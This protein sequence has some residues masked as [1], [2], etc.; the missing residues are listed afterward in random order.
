VSLTAPRP[1]AAAAGFHWAYVCRACTC[2]VR[3]DALRDQL[4][5]ALK[6]EREIERARVKSRP[7]NLARLTRILAYIV[8]DERGNWPV[9]TSCLQ[10][11]LQYSSNFA[12]N[13]HRFSIALHDAPLEEMSVESVR[14]LRQV[15][16]VFLPAGCPVSVSAV[17][18]DPA[19]QTVLVN[20]ARLV[21]AHGPFGLASNRGTAVQM[22]KPKFGEFGRSNRVAAGR[23]P[24][25]HGDFMALCFT[26][27]PSS[28]RSSLRRRCRRS[29]ARN[30]G[31]LCIS[32]RLM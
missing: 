22:Q 28:Q 19:T 26:S 7:Y 12:A 3:Q 30:R 15:D 17:L 2:A 13:V 18:S 11:H 27:M 32:Q 16:Y 8:F 25:A 14:A 31:A 4:Q 9:H 5:P 23:T 21:S 10:S 29:E 1:M 6:T 24:D 20:E